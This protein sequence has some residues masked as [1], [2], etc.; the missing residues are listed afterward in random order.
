MRLTDKDSEIISWICRMRYVT[1]EQV[2]KKFGLKRR[3]AYWR[4]SRL[5][6]GG[7]LRQKRIFLYKPGVYM[8]NETI[9]AGDLMLKPVKRISLL[10][11]E[12]NRTVVDV[13]IALE[14]MGSWISDR[15]FLVEKEVKNRFVEDFHCPDGILVIGEKRI[16]IEVELTQKSLKSMERILK[17]H[18]RSR[19][20][21]EV[22]YL[23]GKHS[24]VE[25][26]KKLTAREEKIKVMRLK[27]I[28][29]L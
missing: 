20:Y 19:D 10:G 13:S 11:F 21:D 15:E 9:M 7:Y 14:K 5:V 17:K 22:W 26:L 2:Q 12:H 18:R 24:L 28:L 27:E 6:K 3:T 1:C 25:W 29:L 4:L 23:A 8:S 16:A